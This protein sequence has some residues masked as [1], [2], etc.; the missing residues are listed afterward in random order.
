MTDRNAK[1]DGAAKTSNGMAADFGLRQ[2]DAGGLEFVDSMGRLHV[3]V[4]PVRG[5]PMSDP[6]HWVSICD[7]EGRE[8][9][10]IDDLAA[11]SPSMRKVVE[12][13]L[14]RREFVPTIRRILSVPADTEPAQWDVETDRGRTQFLVNSADD[15][16]RLDGHRALVIDSDGIRY[17]V[18]DMR[19]LDPASRRILDLFLHYL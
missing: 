18:E 12:Q 2:G 6:D 1:T 5:F 16:R 13:N 10:V 7:A 14:S 19:Q 15:V 17:V 11:L 3:D 8:L 4:E 9:S